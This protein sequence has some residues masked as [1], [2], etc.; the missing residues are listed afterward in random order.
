MYLGL[1]SKNT[2]SCPF[3]IDINK[4]LVYNNKK[5][6]KEAFTAK[7]IIDTY[8]LDEKPGR[9]RQSARERI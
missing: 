1:R 5:G 2:Q 7:N 3:A 9:D 6:R 8:T 4:S